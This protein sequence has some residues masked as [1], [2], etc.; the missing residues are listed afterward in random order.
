[1]IISLLPLIEIYKLGITGKT[2]AA[3]MSCCGGEWHA[4]GTVMKVGIVICDEGLCMRSS[5]KILFT[6]AV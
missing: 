1:M 2:Y 5:L 4:V 3:S 6:A